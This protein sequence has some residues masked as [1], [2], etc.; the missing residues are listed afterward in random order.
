MTILR[1]MKLTMKM[2]MLTTTLMKIFNINATNLRL[3]PLSLSSALKSFSPLCQFSVFT[4]RVVI[5]V[6][7][8]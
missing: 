5:R 3:A 6:D 1:V 7:Y 8:H 2:N 4:C